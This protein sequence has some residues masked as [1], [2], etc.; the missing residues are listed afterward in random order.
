M[1]LSQSHFCWLLTVP[2]PRTRDGIVRYLSEVLDPI[3]KTDLPD[4]EPISVNWP[5]AW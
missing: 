5:P 2:A 4:R 1:A 3:V